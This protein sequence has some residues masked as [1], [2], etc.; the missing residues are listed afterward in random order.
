MS[1][2]VLQAAGRGPK[3]PV[4]GAPA[5]VPLT[6]S[7]ALK[8]PTF[9]ARPASLANDGGLASRYAQ[10]VPAIK[11]KTDLRS[12]RTQAAESPV[13]TEQQTN[14]ALARCQHYLTA[15]ID[16]KHVTPF[17]EDWAV[18]AVSMLP[19]H[20]RCSIQQGNSTTPYSI[21]SV[22]CSILVHLHAV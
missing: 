4:K 3:S 8:T 15:G 12:A 9:Q 19:H 18:N 13:Y 11:S 20:E 1:V 14:E 6:A 17:Q 21:L 5:V 10:L 22:S 7:R 16:D 2:A